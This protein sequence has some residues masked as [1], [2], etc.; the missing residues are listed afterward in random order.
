MHINVCAV[1]RKQMME[2][3]QPRRENAWYIV[4]TL[5]I[6]LKAKH[7]LLIMWNEYSDSCFHFCSRLCGMLEGHLYDGL[8]AC[9]TPYILLAEYWSH[10]YE[11]HQ[12]YGMFNPH[13]KC[14]GPF[15]LSTL[16][17]WHYKNSTTATSG[18]SYFIQT[19]FRKET[20]ASN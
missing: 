17:C 19:T 12:T 5:I 6:N 2:T 3:W 7:L 4:G 8:F 14:V 20:I 11:G 16:Y 18:D 10:R 13:Q 15:R 1:L 9:M